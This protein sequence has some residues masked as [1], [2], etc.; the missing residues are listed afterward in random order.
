MSLVT[1]V[2]TSIATAP[3]DEEQLI[4]LL[5][6]ARMN[7]AMHHVTGMLLYRDSTFMQVLEGNERVILALESRIKDDPR[8]TAMQRTLFRPIDARAFPGWSMGFRDV[9]VLERRF[10]E[11]N[12]LRPVS[13]IP[14]AASANEVYALLEQFRD[15]DAPPQRKIGDTV[16][17]FDTSREG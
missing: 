14:G 6:Q 11:N 4:Q 3:L 2:Y 1:L 7:N 9:R 10:G 17:F 13:D 12:F 16:E 15:V 5:A 8:H